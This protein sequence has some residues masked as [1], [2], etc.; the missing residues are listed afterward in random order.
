MPYEGPKEMIAEARRQG[1]WLHCP[2]Q[3]LWFSPDRLERENRDGKFRWGP[4]NWKLRD[5]NE[6]AELAERRAA[7]AADEAKRIRALVE[8]E[9]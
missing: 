8:S 7:R 1:L 9:S 2:H 4:M 6:Y 5:P 3:D